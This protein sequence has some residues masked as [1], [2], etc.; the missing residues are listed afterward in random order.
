MPKSMQEDVR[1]IVVD[2]ERQYRDAI[3]ERFVMTMLLTLSDV[4]GFGYDRLNRAL[5]AFSEILTGYNDE[6]YYGIDKSLQRMED[7]N[8]MMRDQ[9]A[10]RGIIVS[11]NHGNIRIVTRK[12]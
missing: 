5:N 4:F 11:Q 3:I 7:A 12:R 8:G 2:F 1:R 9:L 10:E 6:A